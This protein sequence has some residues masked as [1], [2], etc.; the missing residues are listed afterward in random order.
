MKR[1]AVFLDRDGVINAYVYNSEFG[2]VDSP[3]HPDDFVLLPGAARAIA[4][5]N[6]TGLPIIVVS[7]Q[8]GIAKR[9]FNSALLAAMTE[10]MHVEARSAGG[11]LDAVYYCLH[12]PLSELPEY[13]VNCNCRKPSPGLLIQAAKELDL[14]LTK[15]YMVGDGVTDIL[16]GDSAGTTTIF[17]SA[18][19]CY[20]C[21]ELV[22][23]N[24][25]PTLIVTTLLEAVKDISSMERS[26]QVPR[27]HLVLSHCFNFMEGK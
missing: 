22:R 3:A 12:H 5:L 7:N 4:E 17:I 24:A 27:D 15:S 16:A 18:R 20:I 19:K 25:K 11:C 6:Q 1:G 26:I 23:Q 10:K 21:D 2:T 8:P 14:D 9:K 13:K